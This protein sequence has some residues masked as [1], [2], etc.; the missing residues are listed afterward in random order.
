MNAQLAPQLW[1]EH[2]T[3]CLASEE[4]RMASHPSIEEDGSSAAG[5]E[6]S[7][8]VLATSEL[9]P[10]SEVSPSTLD[11]I[12]QTLAGKSDWLQLHEAILLLRRVVVHHRELVK[13]QHVDVFL[14]P[15]ALESDS[16]RSTPAK[17]AL[18]A[19]AECFEFL[20]RS[21]LERSLLTG[22]R[23][24][25]LDVLLRRSV[26]E[27]KFLRDAAAFAVQKLANHLAGLPLLLAVAKY[28]SNKNAKLCGIAAWAISLSLQRLQQQQLEAGTDI[29]QSLT[30]KGGESLR[31]VY[32]ALAVFRESK[33]ASARAEATT[34]FQRL[35]ELLGREALES[36]LK[37]AL[38]GAGQTGVVAR[39]LKDAFVMAKS[40]KPRLVRT[41]S[42]RERM[43]KDA[44]V[45]AG[46]QRT[47][48]IVRVGN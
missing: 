15:L 2:S 18:L 24:E 3:D 29:R 35:G 11:G 33:D 26:C 40:G 47:E 42:L 43:V 31:V 41:G 38:S 23:P 8:V 20:P 39:I 34:S 7:I 25:I 28:G 30:H 22:N 10:L 5:D 14:R 6:K 48:A 36:G 37:D 16:L 1:D 17:N 19:C 4:K 32:R 21:V 9:T 13:T 46:G 45:G 27:K 44:T 12:I